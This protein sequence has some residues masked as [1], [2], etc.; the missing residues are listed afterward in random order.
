MPAPSSASA[1][2]VCS[3]ECATNVVALAVVRV[4]SEN[5]V[6]SSIRTARPM[7]SASPRTAGN[8]HGL[9]CG[10]ACR[11]LTESVVDVYGVWGAVWSSM[12]NA[13]SWVSPLLHEIPASWHVVPYD[14]CGAARAVSWS[15]QFRSGHPRFSTLRAPG[16]CFSYSHRLPR[17]WQKGAPTAPAHNQQAMFCY[18]A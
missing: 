8:S 6:L 1:E 17:A 2:S 7:P 4:E 15:A 14:T 13:V 10:Q 18:A 9:T 11:H 3:S 5:Q 12:C 16:H